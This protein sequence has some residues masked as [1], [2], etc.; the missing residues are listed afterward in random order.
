MI[1]GRLVVQYTRKKSMCDAR[2][3]SSPYFFP[4]W[5]DGYRWKSL[6]EQIYNMVIAIVLKNSLL[7]TRSKHFDMGT[8]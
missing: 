3:L 6:C 5:D 4:G 2:K 1:A 8:F 7:E